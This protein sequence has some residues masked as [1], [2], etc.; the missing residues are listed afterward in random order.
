MRDAT[1]ETIYYVLIMAAAV[2]AGL[3]RK[4]P[5]DRIP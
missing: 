4:P 1:K 2:W 3:L 5:F